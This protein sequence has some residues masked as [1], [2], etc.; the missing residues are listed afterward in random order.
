IEQSNGE[1]ETHVLAQRLGVSDMT[2]RRDLRALADAGRLRRQHGGATPLHP[3][4]DAAPK[5]IGIWLVSKAGKY[6]DPFLNEVLAG[7]DQRLGELGYRIAYVNTPTEIKSAG[8]ARD[9][10][11]SSAIG[12]VMLLGSRL[13]DASIEY[14]K[15]NVR[16]LVAAITPIG[17]VYDAITFDGF[18]G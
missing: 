17:P 15:A 9:L 13:G 11:Q 12:G 5:A 4:A 7:A 3:N 16:V 14:I 2:I 6:S 8:E 10:L 1:L 18:N